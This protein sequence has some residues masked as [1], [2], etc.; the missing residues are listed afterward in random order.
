MRSGTE[1]V[2]QG[3]DV[4]RRSRVQ[5]FGDDQCRRGGLAYGGL[6]ALTVGPAPGVGGACVVCVHD[7]A[8]LG[9]LDVPG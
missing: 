3:G 8:R 1:C 9:M 7:L 6:A 2:D 5:A 4:A